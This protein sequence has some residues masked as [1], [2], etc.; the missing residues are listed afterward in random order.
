MQFRLRNIHEFHLLFPYEIAKVSFLVSLT[1]LPYSC[2]NDPDDCCTGQNSNQGEGYANA[3][4]IP[5]GYF[6]S[7]FLQNADTGNIS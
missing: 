3:N 2:P 7:L 6:I 4:E 1:R 5:S